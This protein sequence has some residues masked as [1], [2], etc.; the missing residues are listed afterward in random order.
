MVWE[1]RWREF[2]RWELWIGALLPLALIA[3]WTLSIAHRADGAAL[4]RILFW[5]NLVGRAV[6]VDAP[7]PYAYALAHRNTPGKYL[8]ELLID[9]LPW[10]ALLLC[11]LA[12]IG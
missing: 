11:A 9:L 10:T 2:V 8:L 6:A 4:L 3:A 7:T 5:D 12:R 1:R